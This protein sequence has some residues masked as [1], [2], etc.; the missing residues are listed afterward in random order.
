[1]VDF[2]DDL[3]ARV[4]SLYNSLKK[5]IF[6]DTFISLITNQKKKKVQIIVIAHF[7]KIRPCI[8]LSDYWRKIIIAFRSISEDSSEETY[9]KITQDIFRRI[10]NDSSSCGLCHSGKCAILSFPLNPQHTSNLLQWTTDNLMSL[11]EQN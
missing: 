10:S 7:Q 3:Y 2:R 1:M 6:D 11:G 4:L 9:C 8:I 5:N